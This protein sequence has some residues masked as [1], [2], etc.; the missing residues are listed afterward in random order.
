MHISQAPR[1]HRLVVSV[2][3]HDR[4]AVN[5]IAYTLEGFVWK[6]DYLAECRCPVCGDSK[7]SKR[8]KR[9]G[10]YRGHGDS[11]DMMFVKCHNCGYGTSLRMFL[12][13]YYPSEYQDYLRNTF[14]DRI[15][16]HATPTII[17]IPKKPAVVHGCGYYGC[18]GINDSPSHVKAYLGKRSIP[19]DKMNR[20]WY[21]PDFKKA[22]AMINAEVADRINDEPRLVLPFFDENKAV[23]ALQGRDL[24][25]TSSRK[26]MLIKREGWDDKRYGLDTVDLSKTHYVVE[27][28]IDSLFINNAVA[29]ND[30]N[31][32]RH[33]HPNAVYIP[34]NQY[35]HREVV[36]ECDKVIASGSPIV[37][38]PKYIEGKD[39]NDMVVNGVDIDSIIRNNTFAGLAARLRF[40][41]LRGI[42]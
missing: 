1:C 27:G 36:A 22:V 9:F 11:A 30:L 41:Q 23:V 38:F 26:Y 14:Q 8:K 16:K 3:H 31:L 4:E 17:T 5:K 28:G 24:T 32:L 7:K 13:E 18:V 25:G 2:I 42:K 6:R 21:A 33:V 34:D 35:R 10:F 40:Q 37:L 12:K 15:S 19:A 20:F 29:T 39:I